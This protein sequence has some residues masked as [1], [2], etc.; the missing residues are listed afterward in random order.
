ML[1]F[2]IV[3]NIDEKQAKARVKFAEDDLLSYWLPVLQA[4]TLKDKFYILPDIDEQVACLMDENLEEGVILGAIYSDVDLVP[5]ISKNKVKIKFN[6][7]AE[8]EY[9][10]IEHTLNIICPNI[11]IQGIINHNGVLFNTAGI[12]SEGDVFDKKGSMQAIRGIYNSHT[13]N[14]TDSVTQIPNQMLL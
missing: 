9:D 6:D 4:K 14:E 13:H 8:I 1:K 7:S 2:G 10:R 11:N 12:L 5:V 3:T